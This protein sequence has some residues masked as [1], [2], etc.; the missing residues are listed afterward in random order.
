MDTLILIPV[1][2][3]VLLSSVRFSGHRIPV[4]SCVAVAV[5]VPVLFLCVR[6]FI[7]DER[8]F[9]NSD[10]ARRIR[11][12]VR[13][14][15]KKPKWWEK[16]ILIIEGSSIC[17]F[18]VNNKEVEAAFAADGWDPLVL[19]FADSAANHFERTFLIEGF[20]RSLSHADR[21][22]LRHT[23]VVLFK[24]VFDVYD[25]NPLSLFSK[26]EYQE[27]GKVYMNPYNALQAWSAYVASLP[28]EMPFWER[29]ANLFQYGTLIGR[30]LVMNRFGAGAFSDMRPSIWKKRTQAFHALSGTKPR[31]DYDAIVKSLACGS[32][33]PGPLEHF[34][35]GWL[36]C[37]D[38][39][40]K[41]LGGD[42]DAVA[43]F[44]LPALEAHRVD[45]QRR[46]SSSLPPGTMMIGPPSAQELQPFLKK[47]FWF[48]G[49]HPT[50]SGATVF[51]R[52][53]AGELIRRRSQLAEI[54]WGDFPR[55]VK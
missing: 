12:Q 33:P 1:A 23:R 14:L 54:G 25:I 3:L 4:R 43:F 11:A 38:H 29:A 17:M 18:G 2:V 37:L 8:L 35:P 41:I 9:V 21:Q 15:Q 5:A 19:G 28:G 48:D 42:I 30:R 27:R 49:V 16:E 53:L 26:E 36:A 39:E 51:S 34:P 44:A 45:Y 13:D 7:P 50:G 47:E 46:F 20:L 31:F 6:G 24:E 32:V 22:K 52:W 55:P 40:K 10:A